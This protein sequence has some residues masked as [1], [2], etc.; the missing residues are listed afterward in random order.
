MS[1]RVVVVD[2][3]AFMRM[4]LKNLLESFDYE[5]IGEGSNGYSAVALYKRLKPDIIT[6][7]ITMPMKDGIEAVKEILA[8]DPEAKVIMVSAMGQKTK[9]IDAVTAGATDFIVKPF[10]PERLDEALARIEGRE[11]GQKSQDAASSEGKTE[12]A[13]EEPA[14]QGLSDPGEKSIENNGGKS[15]L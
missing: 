3:T 13:V 10:R 1:K 8:F 2:D 14:D 4:T 5:V 15:E 7:D 9:V 6:M 11:P 12:E